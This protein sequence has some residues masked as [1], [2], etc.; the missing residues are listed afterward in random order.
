MIKII[1]KIQKIVLSP[2][3]LNKI[4][5]TL[6]FKFQIIMITYEKNNCKGKINKKIE[7]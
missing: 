2:N 1:P 3:F 7:V 4:K 6:M 5:R